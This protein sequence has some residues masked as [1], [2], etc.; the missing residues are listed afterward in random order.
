MN[1]CDNCGD[2]CQ[3]RDEFLCRGCYPPMKLLLYEAR[4][5]DAE[6]E[7]AYWRFSR[8]VA[9]PP[10]VAVPDAYRRRSEALKKLGITLGHLRFGT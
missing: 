7:A 3:D 6:I 5:A 1:C 9:P 10:A 8:F 2:T 4:D